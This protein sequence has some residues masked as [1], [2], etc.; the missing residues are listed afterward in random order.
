M[1]YVWGSLIIVIGLFFAI[2]AFMKSDFIVYKILT[3]RSRRLWKDNVHN[4]YKVI[5]GIIIIVGFLVMF[6]IIKT[7]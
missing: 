5:G 6:S 4:I 7:N 2:C 1:N 3:A